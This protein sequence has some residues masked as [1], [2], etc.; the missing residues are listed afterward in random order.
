MGGL[1]DKGKSPSS[2]NGPTS[3]HK[4][5]LHKGTCGLIGFSL[6][7]RTQGAQVGE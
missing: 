2:V 7:E 3:A 1:P 6:V 4:R 5:L